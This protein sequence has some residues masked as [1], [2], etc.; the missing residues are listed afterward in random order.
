MC[1]LETMQLL[2]PKFEAI[3]VRHFKSRYPAGRGFHRPID[4]EYSKN[5]ARL[6]TYID[7]NLKHALH[8]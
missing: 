7:L 5:L 4:V 3:E 1:S 2:N 6:D 8:L